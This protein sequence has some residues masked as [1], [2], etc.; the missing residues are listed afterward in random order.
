MR[1]TRILVLVTALATGQLAAQQGGINLRLAQGQP[2]KYVPPLCPLKAVNSKVEKGISS[3]RKAYEAKTP[4]D[5]SAQLADSKQNIL[6][7]ITQEAQGG[8][9]AAWYFLGRVALMQGD[10]AGADSAFTKALALAPMCEI[11]ITQYRQNNWAILGQAGVEMQRK[12]EIDSAMAQF[13]D[14]NLLF[15][16]LPH[17]YTNMGVVFAN[18][19]HDDSAAVYFARALEISEKDTSLVEDRNSVALNLAIMYQRINKNAEAIA[20]LHKYL[21]WKP[22]DTDA[23]KSL[24]I[25]FRSAGMADSADAIESAM[26]A[27]FAVMNL[28]SLD[29][30]DVMS[31]GVVAFNKG[32]YSD[33]EKAFSSAAKRNPYGRD[34]RYNLANT[35]LA[36]A[37]KAADSAEALRKLAKTTKTPSEVLKAQLADTVKLD[38][39]ASAANTSL[40][41]EAAKLVELEPMNDDDLRLLAQGQRALKQNDAVYKTAERL[42]AL[43]F[44]IEATLFQ[45]GKEG[46]KFAG[47]A[48]GR[49]AQ[50]A[51]GKP[52]KAVPMTLVFEFVDVTGAVK[53]SKEVAVPALTE[54]QKH[55][56][57]LDAKGAGISAW[58]YRVKTG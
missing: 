49:N 33:A 47:E 53:D 43:P 29:A 17:V 44:N 54:G 8:N 2:P 22:D 45:L 12:G 52:I 7:A 57:Q 20:V 34:A 24:A 38:A 21:G 41:A 40:V 1:S 26:I 18:T 28:D 30:Q 16:G 32:R 46:A 39:Q 19:D 25:A 14:A 11:D 42:V 37:A 6:L 31:V 23:Q 35:Y 9:G 3:L 58:R 4:A 55:A 36:I 5:R 48:V 51:A 10:P 56:I 15:R 50:D 27:K 13:R